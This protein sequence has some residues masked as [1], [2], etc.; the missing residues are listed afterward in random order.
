MR[1]AIRKCLQQLGFLPC[2]FRPGPARRR[3][4]PPVTP[5]KKQARPGLIA[6]IAFKLP[7][8]ARGDLRET[9]TA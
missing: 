1:P 9:F 5:C 6:L 4:P 2:G 7:S 8:A 3:I